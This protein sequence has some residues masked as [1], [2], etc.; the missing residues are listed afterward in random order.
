MSDLIPR[1]DVYSEQGRVRR[2]V[3]LH[4][5]GNMMLWEKKALLRNLSET[6]ASELILW[7]C[8]H[9]GWKDIVIFGPP[10]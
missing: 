9:Q 1:E 10:V 6:E 3:P 8:L 4:R 7:G 5:S 2:P